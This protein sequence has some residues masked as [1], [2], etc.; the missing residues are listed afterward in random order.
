[1][2]EEEMAMATRT[3][4]LKEIATI[5]AKKGTLKQRVGCF[6]VIASK[7]PAWFKPRDD[8]NET[9]ATAK[10]TRSKVKYLLMA[11]EFPK[12]QK[13]LDNPNVWI[14]DTGASVVYT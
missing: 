7:I 6:P 14:G 13:L 8:G 4:S 3:T 5:A 12:N 1:V 11:M 10:E 2:E 9:G